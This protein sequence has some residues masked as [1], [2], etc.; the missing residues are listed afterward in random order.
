MFPQGWPIS[1]TARDRWYAGLGILLF[2]TAV[3]FGFLN[4]R[5]H[6]TIFTL[7]E[8]DGRCYYVYLP[9]VFLDGDLDFTNQILEHWDIDFDPRLL[10]NREQTG[11]VP[12]KYP[13]GLALT[14]LPAF[15]VGHV[16]TLMSG[17]WL[18]PDGYS[19]MYQLSCLAWIQFLTWLTLCRID[20]LVTERLHVTP[21]AA[22]WGIAVVVLGTP[23]LYYTTREPFMVHAVS[24]FWC[25]E[26]VAVAFNSTLQAGVAW[27]RL[28]FAAA[29]A[30]VCR[31]TNMFL[32]PVAV[33]GMGGR[34]RADGWRTTWQAFPLASV[35]LFPLGLQLLAWRIL[36]GNWLSYS[37]GEEGFDWFHPALLQTL[38]SSQH[39]LFF[40]TPILLLA[41]LVLLRR[42][43][44]PLIACWLLGAGLLWYVNSAWHCWWFGAAFGARAFVE[45]A[46][47][48]AVG[49]SLLFASL[50]HRP[51]LAT[52]LAGLVVASNFVLM[53]LYIKQWIP[54]ESPLLR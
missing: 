13:T 29:M 4:G 16:L 42:A 48:F 1:P 40:W 9:S 22:L 53:G 27:P 10:G 14:L 12:N 36:T 38:F 41:T 49:L 47:L 34:V 7:L 8:S 32:L 5:H 26:L 3:L 51:R 44:E 15:L 2:A 39:G 18:P 37:Y 45:L 19:L 17:G 28:A 21:A 11:L 30:L 46:G 35:A 24:T 52:A 31:P 23:Y 33:F 20:R 50:Q 54:H 43:R 25:T 6:G